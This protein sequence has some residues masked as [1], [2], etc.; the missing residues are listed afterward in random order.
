M[1]EIRLFGLM[2]GEWK[3]PIRRDTQA[4]S[5]LSYRK[6][7]LPLGSVRFFVCGSIFRFVV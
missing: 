4:L 7:Q 5:A 1:R 2:S 6:G 3:R